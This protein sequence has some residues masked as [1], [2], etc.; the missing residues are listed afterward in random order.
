MVKAKD[1]SENIMASEFEL[2]TATAFEIFNREKIEIGIVEVGLGGR[3]DAT[4][5]LE[6]PSATVIT[7][8]GIDHQSLLGET[9]E[10]IA[11]QKAGIMK[12][13]VP[14]VIDG[15]NTSSVLEVL[16]KN[17][18][19]VDA[20]PLIVI[21][22]D[23]GEDDQIW[24]MLSKDRFERHQQLNVCLAFEAVHGLL[25]RSKYSFDPRNI[26]LGVEKTIWPGRLQMLSIESISD[27]TQPIL[28]DGA[29]NPQ[30]AEILGSY[31]DKKLRMSTCPVT[32][33]IAASQGRNAQ[34]LLSYLVKPGDNLVAVGFSPVDGMPWVSSQEAHVVLAAGRRLGM[35]DQTSES[36]GSLK[37]SIQ[38]ATQLA[39]GGPLVVAGSL[40]LASDI[41]RLLR[42][43]KLDRAA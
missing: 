9:L 21:R 19:E 41:L 12:K 18:R 38:L 3:Q 6:K 30:S 42:Q 25:V 22:Q 15:S 32:W 29:H 23:A 13:D 26:L 7:K 2:L 8:I 39:K 37:D 35:L 10:E 4:N 40:Y 43:V 14:C 24:S 20:M 31:V 27:R 33:L 36:T 34:E 11:Y 16:G 5:V 1:R 28:L 17:A